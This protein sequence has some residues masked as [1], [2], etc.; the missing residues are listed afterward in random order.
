MNHTATV[1]RHVLVM[2]FLKY[3]IV[4]TDE[5]QTKF[6]H[7]TADSLKVLSTTLTTQKQNAL[8]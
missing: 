2:K 1:K 8:M 6:K 7:L 4:V 3:V 5:E